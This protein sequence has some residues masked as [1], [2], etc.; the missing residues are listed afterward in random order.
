[1]KTYLKDNRGF[2]LV[3][4][5]IVMIII[6]LLIGGVL[7]GQQLVDNAKVT[8]TLAQVK[9][10]QAS[11]NAFLDTYGMMPGD[12]S[13][14]T[15]RVPAC[16]AADNNCGD[17]NADGFIS[18]STD[19]D[20]G[21]GGTVSTESLSPDW[22][23]LSNGSS[24]AD[25][26]WK[27]LGLAGLITGIDTDSDPTELTWGVTHPSSTLRGGFEMYYD[28]DFSDVGPASSGL[29]LRLSNTG[30]GAGTMGSTGLEPATPN[31]AANMDRKL[32]DG[33]PSNGIVFVNG[34]KTGDDG[35]KSDDEYDEQTDQRNC[36]VYF[37]LDS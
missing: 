32:D 19:A 7:K 12:M 20:D 18:M 11:V 22:D 4:L 1:M 21:S 13:N 9:A 30:M 17:G 29:V 35:C 8:S 31:Q 34:A 14:A 25:M 16:V 36:L 3:E 28:T 15:S 37:V 10:Y 27:H 2:T 24:E 33:Q 26:S 23:T 6:G 5:A